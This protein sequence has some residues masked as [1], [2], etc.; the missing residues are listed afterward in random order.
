ATG[1]AEV[2]PFPRA[3][4]TLVT[5]LAIGTDGTVWAGAYD[6]GLSSW[7]PGMRG[8]AREPAIDAPRVICVLV[9]RSGRRGAGTWG[10]GLGRVP[11]R[12]LTIAPFEFDGTFAETTAVL[13]DRQ[14]NLWSGEASALVRRDPLGRTLRIPE[15][16]STV[17]LREGSD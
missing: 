14:G 7:T 10:C 5:S 15:L 16:P 4:G 1:R 9:D 2:V 8:F 13:E 3:D 12:A 17:A 6:A 11:S